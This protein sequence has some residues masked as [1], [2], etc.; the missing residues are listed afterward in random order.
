MK[1]RTGSK[2]FVWLLLCYCQVEGLTGR[3]L[4]FV[5]YHRHSRL[6][7]SRGSRSWHVT[8]RASRPSSLTAGNRARARG[9][10][11]GWW[12]VEVDP[13]DWDSCGASPWSSAV[14]WGRGWAEERLEIL[15]LSPDTISIKSPR[16]DVLRGLVLYSYL[17]LNIFILNPL[18][19]YFL[20]Y[21]LRLCK[22]FRC[23]FWD[24]A[25]NL[26]LSIYTFS[27]VYVYSKFRESF[28]AIC[29]F[30]KLCIHA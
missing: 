1:A 28:L 2:W 15:K 19:S 4:G 13:L 25:I 10:L 16:E 30:W 6:H 21:F 23:R 18:I 12:W 9:C 7:S 11:R 17:V 26:S 8:W 20:S 24:F 3:E 22:S 14:A 5:P 29:N 27:L